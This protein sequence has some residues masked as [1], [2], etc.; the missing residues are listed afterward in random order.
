MQTISPRPLFLPT[1]RQTNWLIV[2]GFLAVGYAL[3]LR[4]LAIEL[5]SVGLACQAGL[6]T[7]LCLTR[8]IV[9]ALFTNSVFGAVALGA[10][11]LNLIRPA[12]VLFGLG[13]VASGFGIVLYNVGLSALAAALLILSLARPVPVN[14]TE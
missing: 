11:V 2:A 9:I 1:A 3:Y 8:K 13:L 4:Y 5:S 7:W 6:Q 12:L 14:E 10:A